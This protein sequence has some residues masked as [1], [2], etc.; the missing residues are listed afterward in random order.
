MESRSDIMRAFSY[1]ERAVRV[2][3]VDGEPW[4]FVKDVAEALGLKNSS[5]AI[6]RLDSDEKGVISNDTLGGAQ[7]MA[8]VNEAG[9]Y[10]LILSSKKPEAKEFK[11]WITHEVLPAIR[12]QGSYAISPAGNPALAQVEASLAQTAQMIERMGAQFSQMLG[13]VAQKVMEQ[14]NKIAV[15]ESKVDEVLMTIEAAR[16]AS[17]GEAAV[18]APGT[19]RDEIVAI[20]RDYA[21][22]TNRTHRDCWHI[23]YSHFETKAHVRI[24][25]RKRTKENNLDCVERLG[26]LDELH[27]VALQLIRRAQAA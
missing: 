8:I 25:A 1:G 16:T 4:W 12:Q 17:H 22:L 20:V 13:M 9:L 5:Q 6:A 14:D 26:Y 24:S 15:V 11:R 19:V 23:L 21:H 2:V 3:E 7:D 10:S 18:E 27:A